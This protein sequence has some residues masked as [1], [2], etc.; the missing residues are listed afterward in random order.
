MHFNMPLLPACLIFFIFVSAVFYSLC[1]FTFLKIQFMRRYLIQFINWLPQFS[2]TEDNSANFMDNKLTPISDVE[3]AYD[4]CTA[5]RLAKFT[6]VWSALRDG[7]ITPPDLCSHL[8]HVYCTVLFEVQRY[9][10]LCLLQFCANY[11]SEMLK[12]LQGYK[13]TLCAFEESASENERIKLNQIL[14]LV[15][16]NRLKSDK[17]MHSSSW[18][19]NKY[20]NGEL[21]ELFYY[22]LQKALANLSSSIF[23]KR[24]NGLT[25]SK[26]EYVD[27]SDIDF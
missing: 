26:S 18:L 4:V 6:S 5:N 24:I 11:N 15:D 3:G 17:D 7:L 8:L 9:W 12:T 19:P 23:R 16:I 22:D 21:T 14:M 10:I 1:P 20:V 13:D 25:K 2:S 27:E